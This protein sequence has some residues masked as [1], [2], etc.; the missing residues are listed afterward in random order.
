MSIT[1]STSVAA[2]AS[3]WLLTL[4]LVTLKTTSNADDMKI[5][6]P[7]HVVLRYI[8]MYMLMVA[9]ISVRLIVINFS[10]LFFISFHTCYILLRVLYLRED[11][12]TEGNCRD[13]LLSL[14]VKNVEE[15][16]YLAPPGMC[17]K[18][19]KL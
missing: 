14:A 19:R 2:E 6:M 11:E 12:V 5:T 16:Y 4:S 1:R 15:L 17:L 9:C 10:Y 7:V 3:T 8:C 18:R 13:E